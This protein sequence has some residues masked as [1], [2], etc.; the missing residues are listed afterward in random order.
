MAAIMAL[1]EDREGPTVEITSD[2]DVVRVRQL[3]RAFAAQAGMTLVDQT[4]L[5]TAASEL[6]R[7]TLIHGGGGTATMELTRDA[8]RTGVRVVFTD[9]GPGIPDLSLALTDGWTSG[10]GLGLG[11]SGSRRLVDKFEIDTEV[12]RG[13]RILIVKWGR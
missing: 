8:A 1:D 10:S 12:D 5:I 3:V 11:L 2:A 7:N 6:A 9:T 13:T 4:K